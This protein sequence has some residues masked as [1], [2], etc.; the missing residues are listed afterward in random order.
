ML[1]PLDYAKFIESTPHPKGAKIHA[2]GL[3]GN[4]PG[5]YRRLLAAWAENNYLKVC[6]NFLEILD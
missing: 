3:K 1:D 6:P 5:L 4:W 2:I